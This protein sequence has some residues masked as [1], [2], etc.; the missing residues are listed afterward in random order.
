MHRKLY[1]EDELYALRAH[2]KHSV[3][4]ESE[5]IFDSAHTAQ[6]VQHISAYADVLYSW[7]LFAKRAELLKALHGGMASVDS[8]STDQG[9][10]VIG[11]STFWC[12]CGPF[13]QADS[14]I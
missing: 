6:F 13:V 2:F 5:P 8:S 7:E 9:H 4:P 12:L 3:H 11:S 14:S 10:L 1:T